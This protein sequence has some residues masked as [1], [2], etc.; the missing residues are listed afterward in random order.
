MPRS[1]SDKQFGKLLEFRVALRTFM[2][3]SE[4]QAAAVGLSAAQHQLLVAIRGHQGESGPTITDVAAY[5]LVRH[6]SAVGLIDRAQAGGLVERYADP[7]DQRVVRL[8]LTSPGRDRVEALA[9]THLEELR[10][11]AP[12]LDMLVKGTDD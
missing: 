7:E 9:A 4:G 6:H 1:L 2:R 5:L 12:L 10:R 3:W 11:L 8:R